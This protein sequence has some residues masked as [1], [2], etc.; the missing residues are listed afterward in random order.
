M[1]KYIPQSGKGSPK[2]VNLDIDPESLDDIVCSECGS[3]YFYQINGFKRLSAIISPTG[4]EQI[5]P[6]PTYRC[7]D[8]GNINEE[9]QIK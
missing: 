3:K 6:V 5:I 2:K 9:F 1:S 8:C 4:K 7:S